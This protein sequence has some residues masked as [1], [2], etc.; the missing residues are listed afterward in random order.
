M[1]IHTYLHRYI[2]VIDIFIIVFYIKILSTK[3]VHRFLL[4]NP[5]LLYKKTTSPSLSSYVK[6]MYLYSFFCWYSFLHTS[7]MSLKGMDPKRPL[8]DC[9]FVTRCTV[10]HN[11]GYQIIRR[12]I[13]RVEVKYKKHGLNNIFFSYTMRGTLHYHR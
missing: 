11:N 6:E 7:P 10:Q 1:F 5:F 8:P 3:D 9:G 4:L 13:S 2:F 12:R